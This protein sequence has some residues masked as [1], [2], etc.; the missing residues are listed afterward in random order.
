MHNEPT[1]ERFKRILESQL[2][3]DASAISGS[4]LLIEDLGC[5]SLDA[6]ELIIAV[7]E[8]FGVAM[9]GDEEDKATELKS[10]DEAVKFIDELIAQ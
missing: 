6:I 4:T 2:G 3:T 7:E 9:S 8:E 10:V 5:D 1:I